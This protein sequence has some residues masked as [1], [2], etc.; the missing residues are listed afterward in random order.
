MIADAKQKFG[1]IDDALAL[2][3]V[4]QRSAKDFKVLHISAG[5]CRLFNVNRAELESFF[6]RPTEETVHPDDYVRVIRAVQKGFRNP[7]EYQQFSYRMR[8][9]QQEE[10]VWLTSCIYGYRMPDGSVLQYITS[11]DVTKEYAERQNR[12]EAFSIPAF[13]WKRFWIPRRQP[14]SGRTRTGVSSGPIRPFWITMVFPPSRSFWG[15]MMKIWAGIKTKN[16]FIAMKL[17]F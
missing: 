15:K 9:P 2:V 6:L 4:C 10:Y 11:L 16:L 8:I 7:E 3:L 13:C 12:D 14:C 1:H 17:W 5:L